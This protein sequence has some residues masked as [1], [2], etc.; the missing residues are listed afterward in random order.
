[1][2]ASALGRLCL[3][4]LAVHSGAALAGATSVQVRTGDHDGFGRVVMDV[5]AGCSTSVRDDAELVTVSLTPPCVATSRPRLPRNVA[6][7]DVGE[8]EVTIRKAPGTTLRRTSLGTRLVLDFPDR[9]T[10]R[11]PGRATGQPS[12]PS[13]DR[14]ARTT[15]GAGPPRLLAVVTAHDRRD[16]KAEPPALPAPTAV[17]VAAAPSRPP[18]PAAPPAAATLQIRA[19]PPDPVRRLPASPP[20]PP[21]SFLFVSEA[22]VGAAS[23]R[24]IGTGVVVFD[25][26][27]AMDASVI[28]GAL[29]RPVAV[30]VVSPIA[31]VVDIPLAPGEALR[32]RRRSDGWV[33]SLSSASSPGDAVSIPAEPEGDAIVFRLATPGRVVELAEPETG[34]RALIGTVRA[35]AAL[36]PQA[37]RLPDYATEQTWLGVVLRPTSATVDMQ[38]VRTGFVVR[39][40]APGGPFV[41]DGVAPGYVPQSRLFDFPPGPT[42]ALRRRLQALRAASD[43]AQG[44][45]RTEARV[46]SA[47]AMLALGLGTE[48]QAMLDDVAGEAGAPDDARFTGLRAVAAVL[49]GHAG[50]GGSVE[51]PAEVSNDEASLWRALAAHASQKAPQGIGPAIARNIELIAAYP[52]ELRRKILPV[53]VEALTGAG[54]AAAALRLLERFPDQPGADLARARLLLRDPDPTKVAEG[55][56]LLGKIAEQGDR[57]SRSRAVDLLTERRLAD[58]TINPAQAAVTLTKSLYTWRGDATEFERRKRIADLLDDSGQSRPALAMLRETLEIWPERRDALQ[59]NLARVFAHAMQH[60]PAGG[61]E[62]MEWLALVDENAD[63]WPQDEAG[64]K[65]GVR[66][67]EQLLRLDLPDKAAEALQR[68]VSRSPAG[69]LRA[70]AGARLAEIRGR[71]GDHAGMLDALNI[72]AAPGL[73]APLAEKRDLLFARAAAGLGDLGSARAILTRLGTDQALDTAAGL[74]ETAKDWRGAAEILIDLVTRH[75]DGAGKLPTDTSLLVL[76]LAGAVSRNPAPGRVESLRARYLNRLADDKANSAF[77][78]LTSTPVGA[79]SDLGRVATESQIAKALPATIKGMGG[80]PPR[81]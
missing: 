81:M 79:V 53:A 34:A 74:L 80:T 70:E 37:S 41:A 23:F 36:I 5:P 24:R 66:M 69:Q 62:S 63:L 64:A 51:I 35:V 6:S 72:S 26:A 10:P 59:P 39:G 27:V 19:A 43:S 8:H 52:E 1:M 47:E 56:A 75:D 29:G 50:D 15:V 28:S 46:R 54:E 42:A 14:R 32:V 76:R 48:A 25:V 33:V 49:A 44:A 57:L 13:A 30:P 67:S 65:L 18:V 2:V 60:D 3:I 58:H 20:L 68:A 55:T 17:P 4:V 31:T 71:A 45:A 12:E 78:F 11:P 73:D 40:A 77:D 7:I 9:A 16:D 21:A 22:D 61:A 38:A